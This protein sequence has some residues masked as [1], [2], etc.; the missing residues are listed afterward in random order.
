M[1]LV[2]EEQK[3]EILSAINNLEIN[4]ETKL[5]KKFD[6]KLDAMEEKF[7]NKFDAMEEKFDNKFDA[8]EEKFNTKFEEIDE[9]FN[10][11]E[12]KYDT[13]FNEI[14]EEIKSISRSVAV[15][16]VEHGEK[17]QLLLDGQVGILE[18]LDE[19]EKRF[20]KDE[21]EIEKCSSRIWKLEKIM[22]VNDS[23]K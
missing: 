3:N 8:M 2:T 7:D 17:I 23:I 12:S 4:L 5:D 13:K 19:F 22:G 16:E 10:A 18:K 6:A 1:I 21:I 15:I 14:Q 9:R 20:E 11:M